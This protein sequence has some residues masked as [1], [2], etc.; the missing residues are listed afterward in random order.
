[1]FKE[2]PLGI[3]VITIVNTIIN[4]LLLVPLFFILLSSVPSGYLQLIILGL[5]IICVNLILGI[6]VILL[7]NLARKVF[8]IA[9]IVSLALSI[10]PAGFFFTLG[11]CSAGR[12]GDD[13]TPWAPISSSLFWRQLS[14]LLFG[15][16]FPGVPMLFSMF[17]IF[18]LTRS[19]V[20]EQFK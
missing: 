5:S 2:V 11:L 16:M 15:M 12:F 4:L 7:K 20:R 13:Y 14:S 9:Q 6:G 1:M 19:K 3:K 8:V 10:W 17:C 18:Y